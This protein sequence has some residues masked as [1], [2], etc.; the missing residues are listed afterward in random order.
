MFLDKKIC[1]GVTGGI[2][3]YKAAYLVR[4]LSK[5]GASVRVMMTDAATQFVSPL[6]FETLSQHP[7]ITNWFEDSTAAPTSH[8][9]WARWPDALV[10]CPA[11]AN[12]IGKMANGI[13]DN[14][15]TATLLATTAPILICPAMNVQMYSNALYQQNE[16]KL[17]E[18]G[19][20]I[21]TPTQGDL[22]CGET[23]IGRLA[24]TKVILEQLS[25]VLSRSTELV[26]KKVLIT[27]GP[28]QE[29]IDPVRYIS[30][31][32]SGKMG[33]ALALEAKQR[34]ADVSL[35]SGPTS[36]ADISGIHM[37]H[38]KSAADMAIQVSNQISKVDIFIMAAAVADAR[39]KH[40]AL[41][42]LK[43]SEMN[44][45]L[46]LEPTED[47]LTK[48]AGDKGDRIHVGFA[49]ETENDLQNARYK[50][51]RKQCDLMV[52]NNPLEEGAGFDVDT[53]KVTLLDITGNVL[54]L[55]VM[56]KRRVA[57]HIFDKIQEL[58]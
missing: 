12:T 16:A 10:L 19:Y 8:I 13:C 15:V 26:G 42:K 23:G 48:V 58:L 31:R 57:Q 21:V 3:C 5:Q 54:P 38:V 52:L 11:T 36:L 32:S 24:D 43:K 29:H 56:S 34:G 22:A 40:R 6:T 27:A 44:D 20:F 53:N 28:T 49:L 17:A 46:E 1:V 50:Q 39:P 33:F 35:I 9:D 14:F 7:V 30:N 47:I 18:N 37:I 4:E 2:A 41:H 55:P 45:T 51:E 25:K